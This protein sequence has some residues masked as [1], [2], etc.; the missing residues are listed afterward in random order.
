M[1]Y[2]A[3]RYFRFLKCYDFKYSQRELREMS[4]PQSGVE[5]VYDRA[6]LNC[7]LFYYLSEGS[8]SS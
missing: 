3:F 5:G 7:L 4:Y 1:S 6:S 8:L 2:C